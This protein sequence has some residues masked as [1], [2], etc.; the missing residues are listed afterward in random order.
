MKKIKVLLTFDYELPLGHC[1]DYG[2]GLF[3]PADRLLRVAMKDGFPIVFFADICSAVRFKDWDFNGYY[4]R[5]RDQLQETLRLGNDVQLHIHP[6]WMDSGFDQNQFIP[7]LNFSL[8]NFLNHPRL[9]IDGI[10]QAAYDELVCVLNGID[11]YQCVA[12]RAGGYD[13]EPAS[14]VIL[15]KLSNLGIYFESSVI[16]GLY[17]N[18]KLS[19]VDYREH[20]T[21]SK[22][23]ISK[24]GPINK[25]S[26]SDFLELPI[27]SMPVSVGDILSRRFRKTTDSRL[28]ASRIYDNKGKGY[29]ASV[30]GGSWKNKLLGLLNP[31]VLTVDKVTNEVKDLKQIVDYNVK[32]FAGEEDDLIL[33]LI[34][35]PKSMGGYHMDLLRGFVDSMRSYYKDHIE[36]ITYLSLYKN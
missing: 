31:K 1:S 21:T 36:F 15:S 16:S 30:T 9:T 12:F 2:A 26:G 28:H 22:W 17:L 8:S 4:V 14:N 13:V 5:F 29:H 35:H 11:N 32:A 23:L 24:E 19:K 3:D 20:P 25:S 6:H 7:S 33:T 27:T 18:N 34:G 10:I